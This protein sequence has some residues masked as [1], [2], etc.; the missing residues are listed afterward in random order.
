MASHLLRDYKALGIFTQKAEWRANFLL[1]GIWQCL[2][3][4][5]I[6]CLQKQIADGLICWRLVK[7]VL[8][9]DELA[10]RLARE[11]YRVTSYHLNTAKQYAG[12]VSLWDVG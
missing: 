1:D 4:F 12:G 3:R 6:I 8:V 2:P 10:A 11:T 9:C 7:V 5:H